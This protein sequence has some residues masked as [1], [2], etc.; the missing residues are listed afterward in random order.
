MNYVSAHRILVTGGAGFIGSHVVE[1]LLNRG[2]T[3]CVYDNFSTGHRSFLPVHD[4]CFV[5]EGDI[6][7]DDALSAAVRS[8]RPTHFLHLAAIHFIPY[9]NQHPTE[10]IKVNIAGTEQILR[11]LAAYG[12]EEGL[13][14]V[15]LA[16]SAAV[17]GPSLEPHAETE[18]PNPDD[19]YGF[20]KYANEVQGRM[21]F[22]RTGMDTVL[23][24]IFNAYGP[25]ETNP[26]LIPEIIV[27]LQKG[28]DQ[29]ALGNL[30]TKRSYIFVED[31]A[32]GLV[33]LLL[34]PDVNGCVVYN[35]GSHAE[36]SAQDILDHLSALLGRTI[37]P[38]TSTERQRVSD[39]PRLHPVLKKIESL[40]WQE[41]FDLDAGLQRILSEQS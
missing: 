9:C 4:A 11:T 5:V 3:V 6:L 35:I 16:S 8:F 14:R 32:A 25:R 18:H 23:V 21:F 38:L 1:L 7:D 31:L 20:T 34:H 33:E 37:R 29:I 36:Y 17:Y 28:E 2:C 30:T 40:G 19:V 26:H 39:R 41:H 27:Q 13:V 12:V 24:R 15:V 10:A 22:K